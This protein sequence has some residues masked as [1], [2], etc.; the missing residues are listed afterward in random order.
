ML[1]YL[2]NGP[3]NVRIYNMSGML[4]SDI[5]TVSEK[6]IP[7]LIDIRRLPGGVYSVVF[8]NKLTGVS[9]RGRFVVI[10]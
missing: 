5:N 6:G 8:T 9:N 2:I 7:L 4:L 10:N 1:P 3:V